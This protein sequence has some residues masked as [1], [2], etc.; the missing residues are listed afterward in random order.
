M[1]RRELKFSSEEG[2]GEV[3]LAVACFSWVNL[4]RAPDGGKRFLYILTLYVM[5]CCRFYPLYPII[6]SQ[7]PF[8]WLRSWIWSTRGRAT[9]FRTCSC[10]HWIFRSRVGLVQAYTHWVWA[11]YVHSISHSHSLVEVKVC[12]MHTIDEICD[13]LL[14]ACTWQCTESFPHPNAW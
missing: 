8:S 12:F 9:P 1:Y 6:I 10:H 13:M 5:T 11:D 7:Q 2:E 3:K 4:L 14:Y